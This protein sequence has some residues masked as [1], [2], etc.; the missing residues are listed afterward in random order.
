[1]RTRTSCACSGAMSIGSTT[2]GLLTAW[3]TAARVC[4]SAAAGAVAGGVV[5]RRSSERGEQP[6]GLGLL[7]GERGLGA[8][9]GRGR[10]QLEV[11]VV[12]AASRQQGRRGLALD[13]LRLRRG[14]A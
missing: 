7:R 2:S 8:E 11:V 5:A 6:A 13:L 10:Q 9:R 1:M 3:R 4:T 12:V 14:E